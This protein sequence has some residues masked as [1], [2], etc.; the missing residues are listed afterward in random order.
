MKQNRKT[1]EIMVALQNQHPCTE[2]PN[3]THYPSSDSNHCSTGD[4]IP[5][6]TCLFNNL[7]R[8]GILLF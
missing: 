6:H 2:A 8:K 3:L 7:E 5:D 4:I 1:C